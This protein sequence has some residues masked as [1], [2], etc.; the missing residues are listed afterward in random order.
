[1]GIAM[2]MDVDYAVDYGVG[3]V[4]DVDDKGNKII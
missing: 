4:N 2:I 1:M 3:D